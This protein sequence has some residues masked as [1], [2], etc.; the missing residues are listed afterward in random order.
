MPE[1]ER[2]LSHR[3]GQRHR[4]APSR[5]DDAKEDLSKRG[6]AFFA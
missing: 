4:Q 2:D 6:A 5:V 1:M 3:T